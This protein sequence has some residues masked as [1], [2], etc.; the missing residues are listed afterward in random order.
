MASIYDID[1][2][3]VDKFLQSKYGNYK[4]KLTNEEKYRILLKLIIKNDYKIDDIPR[5]SQNSFPVGGKNCPFYQEGVLKQ[6]S[7]LWDK[8]CPF[9]QEGVLKKPSRL[10]DKNCP[11]YHRL[12]KTG[13]LR[14]IS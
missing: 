13:S 10:W 14:D 9:Y 11:F 1:I 5:R 4:S 12:S 6:P 7:R 3:D 2:E 8:N